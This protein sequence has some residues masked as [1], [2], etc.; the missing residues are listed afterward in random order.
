[1]TRESEASRSTPALRNPASLGYRPRPSLVW[2]LVAP[3]PRLAPVPLVAYDALGIPLL[4][5]APCCI[6]SN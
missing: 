1:V 4:S 6:L 2:A 5:P 3:I